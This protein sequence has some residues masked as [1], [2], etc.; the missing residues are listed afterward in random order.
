MSLLLVSVP[1]QIGDQDRNLWQEHRA[2]ILSIGRLK[3]SLIP[4]GM[5]LTEDFYPLTLHINQP[6]FRNSMAGV[7]RNFDIPIIRYRGIGNL[8]EEQHI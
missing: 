8:D 5:R 4:V 6:H 2:K 3:N 1:P 7:E